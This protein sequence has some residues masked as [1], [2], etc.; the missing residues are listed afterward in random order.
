VALWSF[1]VWCGVVV[2][3]SARLSGCVVVQSFRCAGLWLCCCVVVRSCLCG[4]VGVW[5]QRCMVVWLRSCVGFAV[6]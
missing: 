3:A 1:A 4:C 6:V 2:A 5:L